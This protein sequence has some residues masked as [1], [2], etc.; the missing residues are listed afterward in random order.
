MKNLVKFVSFVELAVI[1]AVLVLSCQG[2]KQDGQISKNESNKILKN[3]ENTIWSDNNEMMSFIVFLPDS[4]VEF[5]MPIFYG[6]DRF[7]S[8]IF[9]GKI[10]FK[11]SLLIILFEKAPWKSLD[12]IDLPISIQVVEE[13]GENVEKLLFL[14]EFFTSREDYQNYFIYSKVDKETIDSFLSEH[15]NL[16]YGGDDS[17]FYQVFN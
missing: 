10:I 9:S 11:D 16:N 4:K 7:N 14:H 15:K 12:S 3:L 17:F 5:N 8:R 13:K 1:F 6:G 2:K